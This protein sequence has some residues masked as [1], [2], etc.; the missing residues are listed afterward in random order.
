MSYFAILNFCC[1]P[2]DENKVSQACT[3]VVDW[4]KTHLAEM[5]QLRST[6]TIAVAKHSVQNYDVFISYSHQNTDAANMLKHFISLFHPDWNIFIDIAELQTGVAWQVKLYHSIGN[7]FDTLSIPSIIHYIFD[8][9]NFLSF[10]LSV[11]QK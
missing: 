1:R 3:V 7:Y 2:A 9:Q 11:I 5:Q 6:K 10:I 8:I 4:L